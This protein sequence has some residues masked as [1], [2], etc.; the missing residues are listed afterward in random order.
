[1]RTGNSYWLVTSP[2][3]RASPKVEAFRAWLVAEVKASLERV[4]GLA[5][6]SCD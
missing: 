3:R 4:P 2:T 5:E 6:G 1:V